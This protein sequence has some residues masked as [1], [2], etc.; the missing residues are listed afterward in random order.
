MSGFV[1]DPFPFSRMFSTAVESTGSIANPRSDR[2]AGI[3]RGVGD[4]QRQDK[5][6]SPPERQAIDMAWVR[7]CWSVVARAAL[8]VLV[9]EFNGVFGTVPVVLVAKAMA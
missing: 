7:P 6:A 2:R 3:E 9:S 5:R 1:L 8:Q 4:S